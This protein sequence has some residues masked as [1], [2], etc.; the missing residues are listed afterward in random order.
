MN[1]PSPLR[2]LTL[3][4]PR[5]SVKDAQPRQRPSPRDGEEEQAPVMKQA[6]MAVVMMLSL[7][8]EVFGQERVLMSYGELTRFH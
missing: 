5:I 8:V 3:P 7:C 2:G 4:V 1:I 6:C